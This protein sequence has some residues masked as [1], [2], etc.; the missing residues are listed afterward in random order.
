MGLPLFL[1]QILVLV[2][3]FPPQTQICTQYNLLPFAIHSGTLIV[4][5]GK[6]GILT[7]METFKKEWRKHLERIADVRL[8]ELKK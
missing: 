4:L 6:M 8:S 1:S 5:K 7:S 2:I 3:F